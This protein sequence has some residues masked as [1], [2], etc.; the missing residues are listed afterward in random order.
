MDDDHDGASRA[1]EFFAA[2]AHPLRVR[3]VQSLT[4]ECRAVTDL[5]Q[6]LGISQPLASH[7][8]KILKERGLAQTERRGAQIFY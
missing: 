5:A 1:S 4:A 3:L 6:D 8:L 2:L 7:H